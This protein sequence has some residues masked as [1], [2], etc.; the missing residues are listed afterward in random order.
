[1]SV[2]GYRA[3][4]IAEKIGQLQAVDMRLEI[5]AG[6][7][8]CTIINDSYNSDLVSLSTSL[9]YLAAQ[10]QVEHKMVVVSDI[11]QSGLPQKSYTKR[12]PIW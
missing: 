1:M 11:L 9:E 10:N 6:R 4:E 8:N 2:W 5:K 12:L 3:S 7:R